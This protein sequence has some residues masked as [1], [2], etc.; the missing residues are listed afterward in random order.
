MTKYQPAL[1]L[2]AMSGS[3]ALQ[4]QGSVSMPVAPITTKS[5]A[6]IPVWVAASTMFIAKG[7]AELALCLTGY[8]SPESGPQ[9]SPG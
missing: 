3:V 5:H 4:Q 7:R 9:P 2:R 6:V 1:L 8:S